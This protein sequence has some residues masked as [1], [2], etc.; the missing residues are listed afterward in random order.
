MLAHTFNIL[1]F[2]GLWQSVDCLH[3]WKSEFYNLYTIFVV[4]LVHSNT[5]SEF[6]GLLGSQGVDQLINNSIVFLSMVGSCGKAIVILSK[7]QQIV[8]LVET[9]QKY[10]CKPQNRIENL[11]YNKSDRI[12]K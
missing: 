1:K 10:P 4:L 12:I 3:G 6:L 9:L 8:Y 5:V 2:L 7:H 11:I